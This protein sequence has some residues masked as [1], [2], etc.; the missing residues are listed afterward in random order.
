MDNTFDSMYYGRCEYLAGV[1]EVGVT[2]IAGP[3]IAACAVLPRLTPADD[4]Q[5][6]QIDD[7]KKVKR[8]YRPKFAEIVQ[9]YALA[10]G[11]GIVAPV[12]LDVLNG[13]VASNLAMRR[14][15]ADC[16]SRYP[17]ITIDFVLIDG[18][19]PINLKIPHQ[20][21]SQGASKSLSIAAASILAKSYHSEHMNARHN[22][23]PY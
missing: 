2:S 11:I 20:L 14:A 19:Q 21:V 6:F 12:E 15:I 5:L 23:N 7:S 9:D 17:Q 8:K 22:I 13:A 4:L 16:L 1:D 18:N 10:Y 3:L